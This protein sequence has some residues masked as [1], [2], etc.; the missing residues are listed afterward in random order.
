MIKKTIISIAILSSSIFWISS[1]SANNNEIVTPDN[2]LAK[3][4]INW[5]YTDQGLLKNTTEDA[6]A[7]AAKNAN[8][9]S[10]LIVKSIKDLEIEQDGFIT[11]SEV[12]KLNT[13]M[14]EKYH[15]TLRWWKMIRNRVP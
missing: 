14:F 9:M 6:R 5:I 2:G 10:K 4:V 7:E 11:E 12:R 3:K 15:S 1:V 13:Y 8:E